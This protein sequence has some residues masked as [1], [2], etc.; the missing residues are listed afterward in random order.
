MQKIKVWDIFIRIFH[1]SVVTIILVNFTLFEEGTVHEILGYILIGL[2]VFR[3]IWGFVGS[4]YARFKDFFP[5]P[6]KIRHYILQ[7]RQVGKKVTYLGHNPVGSL[8]IFN[9][10]LTLF[11]V[12]LSGY[13]AITDRF[14]GVEWVE[15]VHEFFA[16]YL[17][18]SVTLHV[19]G[20]VWES[21]RSGVNLISAMFTGI[22]KIP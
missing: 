18:F 10:Y 19:T 13:L 16:G 20:V 11:L 3:L 15:E 5:T 9:L 12:S 17:L 6:D 1:W 8:M 2:L 4:K 14:W 7:D 22:K 21:L